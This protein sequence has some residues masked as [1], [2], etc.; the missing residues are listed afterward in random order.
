MQILEKKMDE[1]AFDNESRSEIYFA[2][3]RIFNIDESATFRYEPLKSFEDRLSRIEALKKMATEAFRPFAES[4]KCTL[5]QSM[6]V[7]LSDFME[8]ASKKGKQD[9]FHEVFGVTNY[10]ARMFSAEALSASTKGEKN[11]PHAGYNIA[12]DRDSSC[13]YWNEVQHIDRYARYHFNSYVIGEFGEGV[14]NQFDSVISL[15]EQGANDFIF[16]V[17]EE[18]GKEKE[19]LA[20][21]HTVE[22]PKKGNVLGVH[23]YED[24]G[25]EYFRK[26]GD[27]YA[28][29]RSVRDGEVKLKV[30]RIANERLVPEDM[31]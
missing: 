28:V 13:T 9:A 6:G 23:F 20:T 19:K 21:F 8:Y 7:P 26:W 1:Y 3:E 18:G 2:V 31:I 10:K 17:T 29:L 15:Y 11:F 30:L 14:W 4:Y 16:M 24:N 25:L 27:P 12:F 22:I 5:C